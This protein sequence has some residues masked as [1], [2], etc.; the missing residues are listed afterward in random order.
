MA[1]QKKCKNKDCRE[2]FKGKGDYCCKECHDWDKYGVMGFG[3]FADV[4]GSE[5]SALFDA[6][7]PGADGTNRA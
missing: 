1:K 2:T 7:W 6:I 5:I 4:D 3:E